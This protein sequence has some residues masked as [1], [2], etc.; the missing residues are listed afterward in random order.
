MMH[1]PARVSEE[2]ARRFFTRPYWRNLHGLLLPRPT[3]TMKGTRLP[4]L[5]RVWLGYYQIDLRIRLGREPGVQ[6]VSVEGHSGS[7]AYFDM[8]NALSDGLPQEPFFPPA[9]P[10]EA[11]VRI[12][13][14]ECLRSI[15][16][17][18][19]QQKKPT[20]EETL[21]VS[22]FYYPYWVWY[23]ARR[24]GRLDI[25]IQNAYTGDPGGNRTRAGLLKAFIG[26]KG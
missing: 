17:R 11:A 18:R 7:F 16:R 15:L 12:G 5:E 20:I 9:I 14:E 22:I 8:H 23:F 13:R 24:N 2:E 3:A 1:I 25:R 4:R 26:K 19:S 21:E 10:E 6:A